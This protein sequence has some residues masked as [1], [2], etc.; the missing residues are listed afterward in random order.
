MK[1]TQFNSLYTMNVRISGSGRISKTGI[2][3]IPS[4]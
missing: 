2:K 1:P 3:Y 4:V